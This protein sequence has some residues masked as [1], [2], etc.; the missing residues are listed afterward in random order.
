MKKR[1]NE[2][3]ESE[4]TLKRS[5]SAP[6]SISNGSK[7]VYR[8]TKNLPLESAARKLLEDY[9]T[10]YGPLDIR[11]EH[12]DQLTEE[13]QCTF[14]SCY[15]QLRILQLQHWMN[16]SKNVLRCISITFGETL[17][18]VDF[19]QSAITHAHLEALLVRAE[20]LKILRLNRCPL[21]NTQACNVLTALAHRSLTTLALHAVPQLTTDGLMW[22]GGSSGVAGRSLRKLK[23]LDIGECFDI[24]DKGIVAIARGCPRLQMINLEELHNLTD[25]AIMALAES[26]PDMRLI[27]LAGCQKLTNK[28]IVAMGKNWPKLV[29]INLTRCRSVT[30]KGIK[31]L[32]FGC[33]NLQA[34]NLAGLLKI[35]EEAMFC[36][37]DQC[38]GL[39]TMNLTG[40]ERITVNG[41]NNLVLGLS[42][43]EKAISFFGFK[44]TDNHIAKKLDDQL[45]MIEKHEIFVVEQERQRQQA[46]QQRIIDAENARLYKAAKLIQEYMYRYKKRMHF[47]WM[48]VNRNRRSASLFIQRFYRGYKGR[49]IAV[50]RKVEYDEFQELAP[51]ALLLQ[52]TVRA[53][54]CRIR[55]RILSKKIRE[56]YMLRQREAVHAMMVPIQCQV[57]KFLAIKRTIAIRILHERRRLNMKHAVTLIQVLARKFLAKMKITRMR[58]AKRNF[59]TALF[60]AG[61]KIARFLAEGMRRYKARLSGEELKRFF[62]HKWAASER[63]QRVFR[64]F[65]ARERVR[66]MKIRMATEYYAAREIQRVYRG[67]R[68]LHFRDMRLNVIAAYVLDRHYVERRERVQASRLRYKAFVEENVRDSASEP[69]TESDPEDYPFIEQYD[70]KRKMKFWQNYITNDI[71]F[72]EPLRPYALEKNMIGKRCRVFW[73]VQGNWYEGSITRYHKRKQRYRV[74]YDDGDHEWINF[75]SEADRV[76]IQL[77]DGSYAMYNMYEFEAKADEVRKQ[78]EKMQRDEYKAQ[79]FRDAKQWRPFT[80]DHTGQIMFFSELTGELRSASYNAN[81]WLVQDDGYGFPCFYNQ[82]SHHIVY[83]DPRFTYDVSDDLVIQ[84]KFVMQEVRL[85][86]YICKDLWDQYTRC[87]AL[88]D[89]RQIE[90][91]MFKIRN[92]PKITQ[93]RAFIIRARSLHQIT[94]IVDKPLYTTIYEELDYAQWLV[95]SLNEVIETAVAKLR[96]RIDQ[97]R[98]IVD[99]LTESSGKEY[100]CRNCSRKTQRHLDFCPNCGKAQLF[101]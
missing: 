101:F 52:K 29:S 26:C 62:R 97:R 30:D 7:E 93:L 50:N 99:K 69:D 44:P 90:K 55:N 73:I 82:V 94:S 57:R 92:T 86:V 5:E 2:E 76:Q 75:I 84:R 96:E 77:A 16:I 95:N 65:R 19:S 66:H 49:L 74:E 23:V 80:D 83:E 1:D 79:A 88:K 68:V 10:I 37:A 46:E 61:T 3:L 64:G 13:E 21:F 41:L 81:E 32:A 58:I 100:Y 56:M 24:E 31:S 40:C 14:F 12:L 59:D 39:L 18:E 11:P 87:I 34:I 38:K 8:L 20:K 78:T 91:I 47:Y 54:L 89:P 53:F 28:S 25:V 85:G 35:S 98:K 42:F 6:H 70:E 22:L 43:V 45:R 15:N 71:T 9:P 36:L 63:L 48:W 51:Y 67:T 60:N 33:K 17:E 72:D 4:S 27:S